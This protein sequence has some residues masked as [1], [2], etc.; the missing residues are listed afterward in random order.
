MKFIKKV[1]FWFALLFL[2]A[3][4]SGGSSNNND[5]PDLMVF[6]VSGHTGVINSTSGSYLNNTAGP[7][8]IA[9]LRSAGY[10]VEFEYYIDNAVQ[11]GNYGGYQE[12]VGD[13]EVARDQLQSKGTRSI[14]IA[15]SHGAVWAHAAIEAVDDLTVTA[16]V[17]LDASSFGW[18]ISG[19]ASQNSVIGGDPEDRFNIAQTRTCASF[20]NAPSDGSASYDLEDVVF[21]NVQ[22]ALEVRGS[23]SPPLFAQ[24]YDEKWNVRTDGNTD[25]L[26]CYY[27]NTSGSHAEVH[28][29]SGT[30]IA[31]V[32]S[33]LK[34]TLAN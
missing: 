33:W 14:V 21:P 29:A 20:P 6:L 1:A 13:M 5:A 11:V 31:Y 3:C 2:A 8:I 30:T 25:G 24:L 10:N 32:K 12:L 9:D 27:S 22:Y 26:S 17:D 7:G 19:H 28:N 23:Q 4:G 15:H 16:L 34:T 18:N